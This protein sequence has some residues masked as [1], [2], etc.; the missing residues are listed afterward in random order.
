MS[1]LFLIA[2][3]LAVA[4][5]P[6]KRPAERPSRTAEQILKEQEEAR[7]RAAE[8]EE[9]QKEA[10][11]K[12]GEAEAAAAA[13]V[14]PGSAVFPIGGADAWLVANRVSRRP[15]DLTACGLSATHRPQ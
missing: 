10:K 6:P 12:A 11:A 15:N 13:K 5:S 2:S 7:R 9:K 14:K 1:V 3:P 4:Q 8:E